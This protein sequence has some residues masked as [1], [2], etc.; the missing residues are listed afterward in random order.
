MVLFIRREVVHEIFKSFTNKIDA[1][2]I[3]IFPLILSAI[4]IGL[5]IFEIIFPQIV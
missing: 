2:F 5:E 4:K 3:F 1:V